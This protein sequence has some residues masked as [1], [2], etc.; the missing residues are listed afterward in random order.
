VFS[1]DSLRKLTA[2][3]FLEGAE[4]YY[5]YEVYELTLINTAKSKLLLILP[6]L[7]ST[8]FFN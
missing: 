4:A 7:D 5:K 3:W 8:H 1:E 2:Y 6:H